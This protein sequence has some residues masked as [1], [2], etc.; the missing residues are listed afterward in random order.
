MLSSVILHKLMLSI[1]L[2]NIFYI[3][4]MKDKCSKKILYIRISP[5][6]FLSRRF[7]IDASNIN[8]HV[9][10]KLYTWHQNNCDLKTETSICTYSRT[11]K[12]ICY[13]FFVTTFMNNKYLKFDD[14]ISDKL[15][16]RC[17]ITNLRTLR[18]KGRSFVHR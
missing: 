3:F 18:L 7:F 11:T 12:C 15:T 4:L 16:Q 8:L 10:T 5:K 17:D 6:H 14:Y 9:F 13:C 1:L 2:T